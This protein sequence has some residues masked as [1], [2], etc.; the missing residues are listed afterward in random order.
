MPDPTTVT[1]TR[2]TTADPWVYD[3]IEITGSGYTKTPTFKTQN[4]FLDGDIAVR[5]HADAAGTLS[6]GLTDKSVALP[7]GTPSGGVYSPTIELSGSVSAANAGWITTAAQTVVDT[8]VIV[9][10]VT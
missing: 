4:T 1:M 8:A 6:L 5:A 2:S 3:T 9:G 10:T 7:M